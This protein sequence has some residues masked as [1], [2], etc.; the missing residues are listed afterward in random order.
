MVS[1]ALHNPWQRRLILLLIPACDRTLEVH[2]MKLFNM[3]NQIKPCQALSAMQPMPSYTTTLC[4]LMAVQGAKYQ[5]LRARMAARHLH[6]ARVRLQ[7]GGQGVLRRAVREFHRPAVHGWH[8]DNS[9][10]RA[11][12]HELRNIPDVELVG[13]Q[14]AGEWAAD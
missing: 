4:L 5:W 13:G 9:V 8:V 7:P 6:H 3:L 12:R 1:H 2:H 10:Q 11:G 14:Q